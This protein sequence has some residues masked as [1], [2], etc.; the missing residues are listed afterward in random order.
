MKKSTTLNP[1]H[2]ADVFELAWAHGMCGVDETYELVYDLL[3]IET[4]IKSPQSTE[5]CYSVK[6]RSRKTA[7][8]KLQRIAEGIRDLNRALGKMDLAKLVETYGQVVKA[9]NSFKISARDRAAI[10][11]AE[12]KYAKKY[13]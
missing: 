1:H 4:A 13:F 12:E 9:L 11:K 10:E 5:D 3:L 7:P 8:A 2:A 6:L